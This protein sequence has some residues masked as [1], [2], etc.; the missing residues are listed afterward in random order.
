MM[1][2]KDNEWDYYNY[3]TNSALCASHLAIPSYFFTPPPQL[4]D[5]INM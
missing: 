2:G 5:E 3:F 1:A 4:P